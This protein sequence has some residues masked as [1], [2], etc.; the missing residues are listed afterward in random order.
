MKQVLD[1]KYVN[2][3]PPGAIKDNAS[4]TTN[5]VDTKG[6]DWCTFL[7]QLGATDIA[8]AAF[9]LQESNASNMSGA[10]DVDGADYSV[11]ATLPDENA[12]NNMYAIHVNCKGRKRYLDLVL[13]AGN[14]SAGTYATVLAI[15][16]EPEISPS[17]A[18]GRGLAA[19]LIV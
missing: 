11:D 10:V 3:T 19:E 15:L 7:V 8:L 4:W 6:F 14:G 13:T 9:K 17:S 5:A 18:S 16:G 12:G 2:V 1:Q